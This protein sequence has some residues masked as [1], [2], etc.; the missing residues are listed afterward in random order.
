MSVGRDHH[1]G[2]LDVAVDD[3]P[4]RQIDS[5]ARIQGSAGSC[6]DCGITSPDTPPLGIP[7]PCY[8]YAVYTAGEDVEA[9]V[10]RTDR[11]VRRDGRDKLLAFA[12]QITVVPAHCGG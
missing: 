12:R 11:R 3:P 1:V 8:V 5:A 6:G 7:T 2:G 4:G 9:L 10:R